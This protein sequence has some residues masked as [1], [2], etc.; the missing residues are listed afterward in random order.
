M[1][2]N[3]KNKK[4]LMFWIFALISLLISIS[5]FSKIDNDILW[6][7]KL[8]EEILQN[9]ITI[10]DTFSWQEGLSWISQEWLFDIYIY[11]VVNYLGNIGFILSMALTYFIIM[12]I[13]YNENKNF[14][15]I[16][17]FVLFL[18]T[19]NLFNQ[20]LFNRP[21]IYSII[22]IMLLIKTLLNEDN[23]KKKITKIGILGILL[24]NI[25]GGCLVTCLLL[26]LIISLFD[27]I[28][29]ILDKESIQ[30]LIKDIISFF[31]LL[32]TG[33]I[34]PYGTKIYE[35][36][37][38]GP[39]LESC[40][41]ISEWNSV[42]FQNFSE[43]IMVIFTLLVIISIVDSKDFKELNR[44][45]FISLGLTC[46]LLIG[47]LMSI[48]GLMLLSTIIIVFDYKYFEEFFFR[49]I[50]KIKP[51]EKLKEK[52]LYLALQNSL[53][54][55]GFIILLVFSIFLIKENTYLLNNNSF[56]KHI[57]NTS[58]YSYK[59]IN[60]IKEN[61]D[62]NDK[63]L[64]S[65]STGN[66]LLYNDCKVFIDSRQH[67]F[68]EE[69]EGNNSLNDYLRIISSKNYYKTLMKLCDKYQIEYIFWSGEIEVGY[70]VKEDFLKDWEI[71]IEDKV[72]PN[73]KDS[74]QTYYNYNQYL[75]KRKK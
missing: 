54:N 51:L 31:V 55:Y 46:A 13:S 45:A 47:G 40:K 6:H 14:K 42:S 21:S 63:L 28:L 64:N 65:Y 34:N 75:F 22:L 23:Q 62:E 73:T 2:I 20:N 24:A 49:Y 43:I 9:G 17:L 59:I 12:L 29:I 32:F 19:R 48:R 72:I 66:Y 35:V 37:L 50:K 69:F 33:L 15:S 39:S 41:F 5:S 56:N 1:S 68:T 71:L 74:S 61:L 38:K 25:H 16:I 10:K 70:D 53:K 18:M 67:P 4:I 7:I 58:K 57:E 3:D 27:G 52:K 26:I 11:L 60:Y 8:G 30:N 44:K 36:G